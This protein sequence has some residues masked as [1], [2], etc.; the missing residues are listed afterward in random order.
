[1]NKQQKAALKTSQKSSLIK[2]KFFE[3]KIESQNRLRI[4]S[5]VIYP[6]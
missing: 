6:N 4:F 3:K 5:P 1:M 2:N